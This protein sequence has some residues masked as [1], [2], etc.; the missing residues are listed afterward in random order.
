MESSKEK[1]ARVKNETVGGEKK[2]SVN[3][4]E[5]KKRKDTN[6]VWD[7]FCSVKLAVIIILVMAVALVLGTFIVQGRSFEE[8]TVGMDMDLLRLFE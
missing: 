4:S 7:F 3:K 2:K 1:S 8:Y 5:Q 6:K